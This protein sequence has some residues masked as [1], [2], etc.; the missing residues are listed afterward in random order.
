MEEIVKIIN[1]ISGKYASTLI[2][3]DWIKLMAIAISN[4]SDFIHNDLWNKREEEYISIAKKYN[5][6]ELNK[7]YKAFAI[8]VNCFEANIN[9]YLGEIYMKC[10]MGNKRT[11]QFFTPFHIS[12][13]VSNLIEDIETIKKHEE[14]IILNE[15]S[16][17][18]R[19]NDFS[20]C[21]NVKGKRCKLSKK[22]IC[23]STRFG[24]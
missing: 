8:L 10:D 9:D 7:L 1:R 16:V 11:G 6:D 3:D 20:I 19:R 17:G 2:F 18:R 5:E 14:K 24:L 22:N 21:K 15:P 4:Q 23:R 12:K 13:A